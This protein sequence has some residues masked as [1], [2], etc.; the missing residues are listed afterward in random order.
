MIRK[1]PMISQWR[2]I[3][4]IFTSSCQPYFSLWKLILLIFTSSFDL[5]SHYGSWFCSS[6]LLPFTLFLTMEVDFAHLY[7]FLSPYFSLWK[8]ILLIFTPSFHLIS[9]IIFKLISYISTLPYLVSILYVVILTLF[10]FIISLSTL[11]NYYSH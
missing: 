2:L 9:H 1:L 7:F 5:I 11:S 6:L 3:L 10:L 4:L 8:L